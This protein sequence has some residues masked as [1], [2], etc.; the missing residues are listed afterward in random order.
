M[1]EGWEI[2]DKRL[3]LIG[4][5]MIMIVATIVG[6]GTYYDAIGDYSYIDILR[7]T[8]SV[9]KKD[10][11]TKIYNSSEKSLEIKD[12]KNAVLLD[13]K[14]TS[15]Y[16]VWVT[17]DEDMKVAEFY[18]E[19]FSGDSLFDSI[20][21]YDIKDN[22]R[23]KT[24]E[25]WFKYG[26]DYEVEECFDALEYEPKLKETTIICQNATRT[27][28]TRFDSLDKLPKN[29][30]IGLFTDT[31]GE[32]KVEWIP[33]IKGFDILEW[34]D[35]EIVGLSTYND[36]AG[37]YSIDGIRALAVS[38]DGNYLF[39][40]SYL[41]DYV[42]IMN[43][44]N[45]SAIV[46]LATYNDSNSGYSVDQITALAVSPDGNYL[47]TS[48][49]TD[50]YVSIMNITNKS[51][52]VPLAT[53]NDVDGDYSI[54]GIRALAVSPDGNYLI[55]SSYTDNYTSIMNI[56]NK[57]AIVPLATYNDADNSY[58]VDQIT[59]L[60]V[61]PDG[62]Y[63][64][65]SSYTDDYVSIMNIT[66]KSAI[67]PLAT[68]NDAD[69][70]YSVD[71]ITALAVSPD[72]N[73][74]ITSSY[75]DD[76]VSI[77]NITNKSAIVPLATYNDADNSYSVDQITALAV[78]PDGNYLITS[79]YT[80]NYTSI[81]NITN[82][83]AIVPLA[84]YNDVDGDYSIDGIRALAVSPDGNYL[85]T[86]SYTD[87]YVSIMRIKDEPVDTT[88]PTYSDNS[89]NSTIAGTNIK[90]SLKWN[91]TVGLSGYIF[92]FDNGTGTLVNDSW[93]AFTTNP[94]WSNV[95]KTV[96]STVGATIRWCVYANDTSNNWNN[97][98]CATPFSY[99][100]TSADTCSCPSPASNWAIN[101]L[102]H[103]NITSACNNAGFNLTFTNGTTT[104][105]INISSTIICD[106]INFN[107]TGYVFIDSDG[108]LN[109]T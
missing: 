106:N 105:T 64:I 59:A 84:T 43:I 29:I 7:T 41:D 62:N 77:M 72:G 8:D 97:T 71:Q 90:H 68:Y 19:D 103:C 56:T 5:C 23:E 100:T 73:Y 9:E 21:F 28:W 107:T 87:D 1:A 78:S 31:T 47:I 89:T 93:V 69:N 52:I 45:K 75:T 13:I 22:Y 79:S 94:D 53:Y 88:P 91:D 65:T 14:L 66:N 55:T 50:D 36:T 38:P 12:D 96:N 82:K 85:I 57:S 104:D 102:D 58:S 61:S 70:S 20:S 42:S 95:T 92:S 10:G 81:M 98:G 32:K 16:N 76:Y 33:N 80:D 67:V 48:S 17:E 40:S 27:N 25:Y 44:T 108:Y 63:L 54:D 15:P 6:S 34:A 49:Y 2:V 83:S 35:Y 26:T 109:L 24:K 51:A 101:M 18:L 39:T 37:D 74:L 11:L 99:L 3:L 30:K 46:P 4:A 60:A 86:S